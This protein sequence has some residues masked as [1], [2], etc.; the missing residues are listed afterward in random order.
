MGYEFGVA[1]TR[2]WAVTILMVV[3]FTAV[4]TL[5]AD[6]DRSQTGLIQV[7]QQPLIDLM[8]RIGTPT[9]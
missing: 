1:G 8:I 9:P 3:A 2:N 4:I 6:L 5:I 7:S